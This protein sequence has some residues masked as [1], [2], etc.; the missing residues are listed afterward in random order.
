MAYRKRL[1]EIEESLA[2]G[3]LEGYAQEINAGVSNTSPPRPSPI[4][5][6]PSLITAPRITVDLLS[7]RNLA[8]V[9]RYQAVILPAPEDKRETTGYLNTTMV[10][11][12]GGIKSPGSLES[13]MR[14]MHEYTKIYARIEGPAIELAD[15]SLFRSP[16]I[17]MA[18]PESEQ[19]TTVLLS[20]VA[21]VQLGKYLRSGGFLYLE[22]IT[23]GE[24]R[25]NGDPLQGADS[26]PFW[27]QMMAILRE[28]LGSDGNFFKL[29]KNH[30]IYH[31]FY[32]FSDGP[33]LADPAGSND[34]YGIEIGGRLVA[35]LSNLGISSYWNVKGGE[36]ML[37]FG[38]N[39]VVYAL[40]QQGGIAVTWSNPIYGLTH[41]RQPV[42]EKEKVVVDSTKIPAS[43]A[44]L[45]GKGASEDDS[46]WTVVF[47]GQL[48]EQPAGGGSYDG[49]AL[50]GVSSGRPRT[51][52]IRYGGKEQTL[53]VIPHPGK[54]TVL[55]FTIEQ[56]FSR[57]RL[58]VQQEKREEGYSTWKERQ[59]GKRITEVLWEE[60]I[61]QE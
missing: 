22:D 28:I 48:V 13:L 34:L 23:L 14:Y 36:R 1:Q 41:E 24:A 26:L 31:S 52:T 54:V 56:I 35:L 17:Y 45:R 44:F 50:L 37:Q 4:T 20:D 15:P 10:R 27:T 11:F 29:P 61:T 2:S 58:G 43:V 42:W 19:P 6:R 3:S 51:V 32:D 12:Y 49:L 57:K 53:T 40:T 18:G 9:G 16:F 7:I 8:D 47:D 46:V 25:Q 39:I 21:K 33:P 5:G 60:T 38:V 59:K 55:R 30:P